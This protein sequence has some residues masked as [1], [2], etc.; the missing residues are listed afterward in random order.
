MH[1]LGTGA[2]FDGAAF[3]VTWL[4]GQEPSVCNLSGQDRVPAWLR[5]RMPDTGQDRELS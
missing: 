1:E 4:D 3:E 5:D 2:G